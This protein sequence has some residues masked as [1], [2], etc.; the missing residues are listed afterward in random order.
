[1]AKALVWAAGLLLSAFLWV[2]AYQAAKSD[3]PVYITGGGDTVGQAAALGALNATGSVP[4]NGQPGVGMQ[5]DAGTLIG[6]ITPEIAFGSGTSN[7]A[8]VPAQFYDPVTLTTSPT[9]TFSVANTATSK[10]ILV[11]GGATQVRVRVSAWTSGTANVQLRA[12]SAIPQ[13]APVLGSAVGSPVNGPSSVWICSEDS[14]ANCIHPRIGLTNFVLQPTA[15]TNAINIATGVHVVHHIDITNN[16]ATAN[17]LRLYNSTSATCSSAT[18]LVYW[19]EIPPSPQPFISDW[20]SGLSGFVTGLS[21]CL[22]SGYGTTDV[23]NAT[24]TA[25]TL[26]I[27]YR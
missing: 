11:S 15:S 22:T 5:L 2:A 16:S 20:S 24:A 6:T 9:V 18:N 14:S 7:L 25:M 21:M 17:Y 1:M 10:S 23:T 13:A 19:V 12:T 3:T 4:L 8:W 27:G 26:N